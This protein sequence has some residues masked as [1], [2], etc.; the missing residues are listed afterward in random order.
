MLTAPA[1]LPGGGLL[2]S[3]GLVEDLKEGARKVSPE[4]QSVMVSIVDPGLRDSLNLGGCAAAGESKGDVLAVDTQPEPEP[5]SSVPAGVIGHKWLGGQDKV[6]HQAEELIRDGELPLLMLCGGPGHGKSTV[7][8][9]VASRLFAAKVWYNSGTNHH[10]A[11]VRLVEDPAA[12]PGYI[13]VAIGAITNSQRRRT[14]LTIQELVE[15]L[16]KYHSSEA[17]RMGVIIDDADYLIL[18]EAR[19]VDF[20]EILKQVLE[21]APGLQILV[22]SQQPMRVPGEEVPCVLV[23]HLS[24]ENA[25][26][27]LCS[28]TPGL[29]ES[30]SAELAAL[31]GGVPATLYSIACAICAGMPP[32][33]LIQER[34][35]NGNFHS[36]PQD[37]YGGGNHLNSLVTACSYSMGTLVREYRD[38]LVLLGIFPGAFDIESAAAVM[39][40]PHKV[41]VTGLM[42]VLTQ[43][44]M[45]LPADKGMYYLHP[46]VHDVL[47]AETSKLESQG[48]YDEARCRFVKHFGQLLRS[49]GQE[50][51]NRA[52]GS[53]AHKE[54]M[55]HRSSINQMMR[56]VGTKKQPADSGALYCNILWT[57]WDLLQLLMP[58]DELENFTRQCVGMAQD[59]KDQSAEA[60]ALVMDAWVLV[61]QGRYQAALEELDCAREILKAIC[62]PGHKD[63]ATEMTVRSMALSGRG[64]FNDAKEVLQDALRLRVTLFGDKH[65][66]TAEVQCLLG[67]LLAEL[68]DYEAAQHLQNTALS[69]R[70][71]ALGEDHPAVA[72]SRLRLAQVQSQLGQWV[73]AE[74]NFRRTIEISQS[75]YKSEHELV[76]SSLCGLSMFRAAEGFADEAHL[77][78]KTSHAILE[79][80]LG[81]N[82]PKIAEPLLIMSHLGLSRGNVFEVEESIMRAV[83]VTHQHLRS[84]HPRVLAALNALGSFK[85]CKGDLEDAAILHAS[86]CK[87]LTNSLGSE[88]QLMATACCYLANVRAAQGNHKAAAS[89]LNQ[90]Q[91]ILENLFNDPK[92]PSMVPVWSGRAAVMQAHGDREAADRFY[93]R[94]LEMSGDSNTPGCAGFYAPVALNNLAVTMKAR[95]EL[96]KAEE[97]YRRSLDLTERSYGVGH[98]SVAR[99]LNN[100]ALLMMDKGQYNSSE[101]LYRRAVAIVSDL[102]GP[103]H[104]EVATSLNGLAVVLKK[105]GKLHDAETLYHGALDIQQKSLPENHP[106]LAVSYNNLATLY[107]SQGHFESS[108]KNYR[109][110]LDIRMSNYGEA[111]ATVATS[112]SNLASLMND[113]GRYDEAEELHNRALRIREEVLGENHQEVAHSLVGLAQLYRNTGQRKVSEQYHRRALNL[114][115]EVLGP[116]HLQTAESC[117]GLAAL[118]AG[119]EEDEITQLE[120]PQKGFGARF[121]KAFKRNKAPKPA[122]SEVS[123]AEALY[124]R[125]VEIRR[126]RLGLSHPE[127]APSLNGLALILKRKKNYKESERIYRMA[128]NISERSHGVWHPS[129]GTS[130]HELA[131]L[132]DRQEKY[133]DAEP[134]YR[135][136]LEVWEATLGPNHP[137]VAVGLGNLARLLKILEREAEAEE[138]EEQLQVATQALMLTCRT[139]T[140]TKGDAAT[141]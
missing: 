118:L 85:C 79:K 137:H 5:K 64:N 124:R 101:E 114:R 94:I 12:V 88:H 8:R 9:A 60:R 75:L 120:M 7:A 126:A 14:G 47:S 29:S 43:A 97:C 20:Y 33:L 41:M 74:K 69:T 26:S 100:L 128:V 4:P 127:M 36:I 68:G 56:W 40:V 49:V 108:E 132:L 35:A 76:A 112:L 32:E 70:T 25:A 50:Y 63:L 28:L 31:A 121:K 13:G 81:P 17:E 22:T 42:K 73:E 45:V 103:D 61:E 87:H 86:V 3:R 89:L 51:R 57:S 91:G 78:A 129:V 58:L 21:A 115:E 117:D 65:P 84:D 11:N 34:I 99:C 15:Y 2:P 106:D 110:A 122:E 39:G 44:H 113:M 93:E 98:T 102:L 125:A 82:H 6:V 37:K 10:V 135:R 138:V 66:E 23:P 71:M 80:A 77:L 141:Q 62:K 46:L 83:E 90:A 53:G 107:Q 95:G 72:S 55:R 96:D 38:S 1:F 18:G 52:R 111:N 27:V 30:A 59:N 67:S 136:A 109:H 16:E 24:H 54:F 130:M 105:Q 48:R 119:L 123:E 104:V 140:P 92:H 19:R 116:D 131:E 134:F 133:S 139:M